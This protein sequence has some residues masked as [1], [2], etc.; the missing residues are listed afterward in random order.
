[1]EHLSD[2]KCMWLILQNVIAFLPY[3]CRTRTLFF[4][5]TYV[6]YAYVIPEGN[7]RSHIG[8]RYYIA[9]SSPSS[10]FQ[11]SENAWPWIT[12]NGDFALN[13]VLAPIC[14]ASDRATSENNCVKTNKD[15][16]ILSGA[17]IFGRNSGFW[18]HKVCADI[19]AGSPEKRR[20]RTDSGVAR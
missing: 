13:S 11:Y 1:M 16:N 19:C 2:I 18:Q 17:P 15:R 14:L 8:Q 10:D 12:R 6:Q 9:T 4:P 3:A 7:I 5:I 20:Q